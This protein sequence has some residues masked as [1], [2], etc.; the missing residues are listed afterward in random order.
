MAPNKK[1]YRMKDRLNSKGTVVFFSAMLYTT[2]QVI[3][4]NILSSNQIAGLYDPQYFQQE[5]VNVLDFCIEISPKRTWHMMSLG[6]PCPP[7]NS[8]LECNNAM[9]EIE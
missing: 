3:D 5:S 2:F 7:L 8:R 1:W 9:I 4:S 6:V